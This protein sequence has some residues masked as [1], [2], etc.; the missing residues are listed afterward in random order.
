MIASLTLAPLLLAAAAITDTSYEPAAG[1]FVLRHEAVVPAPPD[2]TWAAFTTAE[3]WMTWAVP[4]ADIDFRLG[5]RIETSYDPSARAGDDAN[6]ISRILAFVPGRMMAFQAERPPPG[7]PHP[8]L[9]G[10]LFS[11]VEI[12]PHGD[13]ESLVALSGVGYTDS[14]GHRELLE[15]FAR[16]NAWT[17]ERLIE[18]FANGP[19]DWSALRPPGSEPVA[20]DSRSPD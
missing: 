18:R 20:D 7:F 14:P 13:G 19:V 2:A 5:G 11:V 9:L 8:E 10:N 16:G 17:L 12:T 6:I 15:F 3:G 4:F 1:E